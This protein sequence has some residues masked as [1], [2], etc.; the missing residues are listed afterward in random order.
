M[1]D[2]FD[3]P[4]DV[5]S[6]EE[7][8]R[9]VNDRLQR[10]YSTSSGNLRLTGDIDA[11]GHRILNLGRPLDLNDVARLADVRRN[12][13]A[14]AP[15]VDAG[16]PDRIQPFRWIVAG[17]SPGV[18]T[19]QSPRSHEI[20]FNC[21]V[22]EFRVR[23]DTPPATNDLEFDVRANGV[24]V[25]GGTYVEFGV[26]ETNSVH[27]VPTSSILLATGTIVTLWIITGDTAAQDGLFEMEVE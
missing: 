14:P 9:L 24:S 26:G 4:P 17:N 1:A 25:M 20:V 23:F 18:S 12:R 11:A 6:L 10:L 5:E 22:K 13:P 3:I 21:R 7:L 16:G 2:Y 27:L 15:A 8:R 19:G